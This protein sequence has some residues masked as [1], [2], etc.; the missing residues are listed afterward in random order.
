MRTEIIKKNFIFI[1]SMYVVILH[2]LFILTSQVHSHTG[3]AEGCG[4]IDTDSAYTGTA[5]GTWDS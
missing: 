5:P 1:F 4:C 2:F 3:G